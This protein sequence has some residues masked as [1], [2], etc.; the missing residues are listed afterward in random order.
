M[1]RL[2]I[3][4][5]TTGDDEQAP[6]MRRYCSIQ[7]RRMA[8]C[9]RPGD[10]LVLPVR[11]GDEF[12]RYVGDTLGFDAR[13]VRVLVPPPGRMGFD[14]LTPD[15][16]ADRA[17]RSELR[18]LVSGGGV[19]RVVPFHYDR[20]IAGLAAAIGLAGPGSPYGSS[21]AAAAS[22]ASFGFFAQG[23]SDLLNSK[24]TF[25]ALAAGAGLPIPDGIVT[26]DQDEAHDYIWSLL[27]GG[28]CA[29]VKKDAAAGGFGNEIISAAEGVRPIGAEHVAVE[30]TPAGLRRHLSERWPWFT[31]GGRRGIVIEHYIERSLPI[32]AEIDIADGGI[33]VVGH[34]EMIIT[35]IL[36]GLIAPAPSAGLPGFAGFLDHARRLGE[37]VRAIGYRGRMS[38]DAIITPDHEILLNECN[39]R[40]GGSTHIHAIEHDLAG[41]A[42]DRVLIE[43]RRKR[44]PP[45]DAALALLAS[46]G[47]AYAPAERTGILI[48][49]D[50]A[51]PGGGFGE[52]CLIARTRDAAEQAERILLQH[53]A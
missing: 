30:P 2:I 47:L 34:G 41:P 12:M 31:V 29:I 13:T 39:G 19:D 18:E 8:W 7:F 49:V 40:L 51:G 15:R 33:E 52:Y 17:L 43:R 48:T 42:R 14:L 22:A 3:A 5:P 1:A 20:V 4:N 21:A 23:G 25:R 10:V 46:L 26:A 24:A 44:L 32:Y 50:D 38:I 16:L 27:S 11:P 28:R 36:N 35:P 45:L 9:C 37:V 6:E 53:I